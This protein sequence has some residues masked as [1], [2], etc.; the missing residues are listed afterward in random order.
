MASKIDQLLGYALE[1]GSSDLHLSVGAIPMVRINGTMRKL[2]LP[3]LSKEEMEQ[4][5]SEV[6]NEDQLKR[7]HAR[8]E[9]DFSR[10]LEKRGRFRVNFFKQIH[11][12]NEERKMRKKL[13]GEKK[14]P[15]TKF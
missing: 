2:N 13:V 3:L 7:F 1:S 11:N 15:F 10:E 12:C 14:T 8:K 4:I 9:I 5:A 6:M